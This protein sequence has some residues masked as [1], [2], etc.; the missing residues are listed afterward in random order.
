MKTAPQQQVIA[1]DFYKKAINVASNYGFVSLDDLLAGKKKISKKFPID[2]QYR[3]IDSQGGEFIKTIKSC[4][5]HGAV[6]VENPKMLYHS[7]I[8]Q[9]N[10]TFGL[11]VIGTKQ[12]IAEALIIKT[13][14]TIL[15]E[16]GIDDYRIHINSLGD[17]D[18]SLKFNKELTGYLRKNINSI[19]PA[20]QVAFKNNPISALEYIQKKKHELSNEAPR[21]IEFLSKDNRRY[22][23]EIL[24]YLETL[25][26][27]YE[28]DNTVMGN[29]ECYRHTLFEIRENNDEQTVLARGGRYDEFARKIFKVSAPAVGI[30]F[31]FSKSQKEKIVTPRTRKPKVFFI[32]I[33]SDAKRKGLGVIES[34]HKSHIPLSQI[35]GR[36]QLS[37]QIEYAEKKNIKNVVIMGQKEAN[38][39]TVIVR[40]METRAQEIVPIDRLAS[41]LK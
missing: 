26:T 41:Y 28:V 3:K 33:G 1:S 20:G 21:S 37:I 39:S 38:E 4:L 12:S 29:R 16:I 14:S 25:D 8:S 13:A 10:I 23:R 7:N 18:S 36:D 6:D 17:K 5:E 40:N 11:E 31:N 15:N 2:S 35:V 34:L 30:I 27:P 24:E 19:P 22:F 9:K 32:S